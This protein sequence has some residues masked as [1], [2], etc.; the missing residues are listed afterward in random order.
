MLK[1]LCQLDSRIIKESGKWK[2]ENGKWR[3]GTCYF[4]QIII[5]QINQNV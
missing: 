5:V 4:T 1:T 2:V 3:V